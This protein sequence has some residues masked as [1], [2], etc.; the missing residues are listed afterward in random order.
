MKYITREIVISCS[1]CD[2]ISSTLETTLDVRYDTYDITKEILPL[3]VKGI[4]FQE[5]FEEITTSEM[6]V[7]I[8]DISEVC[9]EDL[10]HYYRSSKLLSLA[11][12]KDLTFIPY[13]DTECFVFDGKLDKGKIRKMGPVLGTAVKLSLEVVI[14]ELDCRYYSVGVIVNNAVVSLGVYTNSS[15]NDESVVV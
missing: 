4:L 5:R 13:D 15:E 14:P 9:F 8:T 12:A 7:T 11:M 10:Y 3:Q 1:I 2:V 6:F